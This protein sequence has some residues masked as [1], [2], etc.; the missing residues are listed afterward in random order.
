MATLR[1]RAQQEKVHARPRD[2]FLPFTPMEKEEAEILVDRVAKEAGALVLNEPTKSLLK[3]LRPMA[4][5]VNEV[6]RLLEHR[7]ARVV[8]M[9]SDASVLGMCSHVAVM[10]IQLNVPICVVPLT[11]AALGAIFKLKQVSVFGFRTLP[12][13]A[14]S[15]AELEDAIVQLR[16]IQDFVVAKA[17]PIVHTQ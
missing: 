7:H 1:A 15:V 14:N 9:S 3:P 8:V 4:L 10:A 11:S 2:L 17:S 12:T 13:N 6:S 16:S 5:G